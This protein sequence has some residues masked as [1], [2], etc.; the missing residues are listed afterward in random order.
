MAVNRLSAR[1][2]RAWCVQHAVDAAEPGDYVVEC[3]T[4]DADA[5]ASVGV[6]LSGWDAAPPSE[7]IKV[8]HP[9]IALLAG[10]VSRHPY[11]SF[12]ALNL[13][14]LGYTYE[15]VGGED[16]AAGR[17]DGVDLLVLPGGFSN[18]GL[19]AGER[20]HGADAAL[21]DFSDA[22]GTCIGSC[23]GAYYLSA[24]RPGWTG[25]LP[26][27]PRYTHEYLQSGAAVVSVRL[28]GHP[29][30]AGLPDAIELPYYHGPIYEVDEPEV[31]ADRS[32]PYEVV[33][34]FR[35]FCLPSRLMIANPV[36]AERFERVMA[37]RAAVLTADGPRGRAVLF[38]PHPEMGDLVRKYVAL[39]GYVARY[40]PVR[41]RE[42]MSE[43]LRHYRPLESPSFR[44]VQNAIQWLY[45]HDRVPT[46]PPRRASEPAERDPLVEASDVH[47][48]LAER[49]ASPTASIDPDA[50]ELVA[51]VRARLVA[52]I[53]ASLEKVS[54][55][56][57]NLRA[58]GGATERELVAG[59][60][61]IADQAMADA[62]AHT[63]DPPAPARVLMEVEL[64]AATIES[65]RRMAALER[66]LSTRHAR[67]S[68]RA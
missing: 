56:I 6:G 8:R 67:P 53:G 49:A 44:L 39:D 27:K 19:D 31:A 14:R 64:A 30:G 63:A 13:S 5:L 7:A 57:S 42:V 25:T 43:T 4:E 37:G 51:E 2:H 15:L 16:I 59:W 62:E 11:C 3:S 12:Y 40:L 21:R 52:D 22:G 60:R 24:G 47:R 61:Q 20:V 17:L 66:A 48:V 18:W 36:D 50:D 45:A 10:S 32:L 29:I 68:I 55:E 23:G 34:R 54:A 65:W 28:A 26:L 38:S 41:G 46:H 1:G 35:D 9:R 58:R 33:G